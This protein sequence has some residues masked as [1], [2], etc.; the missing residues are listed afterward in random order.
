MD[1]R[2]L[3]LSENEIQHQNR[4][5]KKRNKKLTIIFFD[6]ITNDIQI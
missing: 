4:A 2:S 3:Q 1:S 5:S 6:L